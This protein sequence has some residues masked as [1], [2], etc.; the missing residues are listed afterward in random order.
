[1][2][3]LDPRIAKMIS[4]EPPEP[5][6]AETLSMMRAASDKPSAPPSPGVERRDYIIEAEH[7]VAIRVHRPAGAEGALPCVYSMHG[8]GYVFGSYAMDD[9]RLGG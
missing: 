4:S 5:V 7:A 8:G 2:L 9:A 6:V 1:V 3:E